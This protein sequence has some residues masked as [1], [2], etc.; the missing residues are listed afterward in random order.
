MLTTAEKSS[1]NEM[2]SEYLDKIKLFQERMEQAH[3]AGDIQDLQSQAF[4]MD[5]MV[6]KISSLCFRQLVGLQRKRTDG[7]KVKTI[8]N[9]IQVKIA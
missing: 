5:E 8:M 2:I 7:P 4:E 3:V 6:R 1:I 9:M